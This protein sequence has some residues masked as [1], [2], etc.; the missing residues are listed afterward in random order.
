MF[1]KGARHDHDSNP[2]SYGCEPSALPRSHPTNMAT[3]IVITVHAYSKE[4]IY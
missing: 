3:A 4:A 1:I 2:G